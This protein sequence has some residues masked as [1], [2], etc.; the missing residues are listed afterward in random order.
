MPSNLTACLGSELHARAT[1]RSQPSQWTAVASGVRQRPRNA[2]AVRLARQ[3]SLRRLRK[4]R[5]TPKRALSPPGGS[6]ARS[7][8]QNFQSTYPGLRHINICC[9]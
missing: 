3:P 7:I 4:A 1:A 8:C 5:L 2:P 9:G 6:G